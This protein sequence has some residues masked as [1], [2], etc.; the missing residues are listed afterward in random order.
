MNSTHPP[1]DRYR[2]QPPIWYR[3]SLSQSGI[4]SRRSAGGVVRPVDRKASTAADLVA[5]HADTVDP[6][7]DKVSDL[8]DNK[9]AGE[10]AEQIGKAQ[11]AAKKVLRQQPR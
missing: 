3:V 7:V 9:T 5:Q 6:L 8:V 2:A 4:R 10:Y 1:C 11:K